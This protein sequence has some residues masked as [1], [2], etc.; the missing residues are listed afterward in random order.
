MSYLYTLL[1]IT[2]WVTTIA[3]SSSALVSYENGKQAETTKNFIDKT[4][5]QVVGIPKASI[6]N[7]ETPTQAAQAPSTTQEAAAVVT[8]EVVAQPKP[9][10]VVTNQKATTVKAPVK[11]YTRE[12]EEDD[13]N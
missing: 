3:L 7:V 11:T 5:Q 2:A 8:P 1:G 10:A 13:D 4:T 9:A 12:P 6:L